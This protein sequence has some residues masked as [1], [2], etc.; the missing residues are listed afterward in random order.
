MGQDGAGKSTV[1]ADIEKWLSWKLDVSRCYLGSGD[2]YRSWQR[3][4]QE[5]LPPKK[6]IIL[7]FISALL[8]LSKYKCL[9]KDV[10]KTIKKAEGYCAKGGIAIFDRYP[11][12]KYYGI[13]DGPKIRALNKK[14][15]NPIMRHLID[16]Y[17]KE[18]ESIL[19]EAESISPDIL[20]KLILPPEESIKRKPNEDLE[21]VKQ[22]HDII[23]NLMFADAKTYEIDATADYQQELLLIKNLIWQN[24]QK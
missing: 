16:K 24:I 3:S 23:K 17:A 9:S 6:S 20:F 22:K 1:T 7:S 13:N 11:Q 5:K 10:L 8:T 15:N 18:E 14:T 4:L 21:K 2:N 19:K 12:T